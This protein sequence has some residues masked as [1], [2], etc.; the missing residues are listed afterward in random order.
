ML[1]AEASH[2]Y[3]VL[4][5]EARSC[6][7]WGAGS[8]LQ[9]GGGVMPRARHL[10]LSA[11]PPTGIMA[12]AV[13]AL[14]AYSLRRGRYAAAQLHKVVEVRGHYL[15]LGE[16]LAPFLGDVE[17]LMPHSWVRVFRRLASFRAPHHVGGQTR[18]HVYAEEVRGMMVVCQTPTS[19]PR[20]LRRRM[21][22]NATRRGYFGVSVEV[23]REVG[24]LNAWER[25]FGAPWPMV[26]GGVHPGLVRLVENSALTMHQ[27]KC[28]YMF[29]HMEVEEN[30]RRLAAGLPPADSDEDL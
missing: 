2:A 30:R 27:L 17:A 11:T 26:R 6:A 8:A 4:G 1:H 14:D 9:W 25:R 7:E 10:A 28:H 21:P 19:M 24:F 20:W 15:P 5:E 29:R 22:R 3:V 23:P 13:V 18:F 16:L 12:G